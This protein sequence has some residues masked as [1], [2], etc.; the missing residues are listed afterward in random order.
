MHGIDHIRLFDRGSV[1]E[2]L[3][4][5][6]PWVQSAFIS[7]DTNVI[8]KSEDSQSQQDAKRNERMLFEKVT[9]ELMRVCACACACAC[10]LYVYMCMCVCVYVCVCTH[11]INF[12]CISFLSIYLQQCK[13]WA[14]EQGYDYHFSVNIDE[15]LVPLER[16]VS[17]MDAMHS[18]VLSFS[19][20]VV[21]IPRLNFQVSHHYI[22]DYCLCLNNHTH[23][24]YNV[25]THTIILIT[26][27]MCIL[28]EC[29][30]I[31]AAEQS[32]P[33]TLEPVSL[34]TLEAYQLRMARNNELTYF[35]NV[36]SKV[37]LRLNHASYQDLHRDYLIHCCN[38]FGCGLKKKRCRDVS[39]VAPVLHGIQRPDD[40]AIELPPPFVIF[41]YA[42]SLEK[43]ELQYSVNKDSTSD[44]SSAKGQNVGMYMDQ[45]MGESTLLTKHILL[46]IIHR[47]MMYNFTL[48][49]PALPCLPG[50]EHDGRAA[51]RYGCQM[52][53]LLKAATGQEEYIRPGPYWYRNVVHGKGE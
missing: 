7:M 36:T 10:V 46:E 33:H 53:E 5:V 30:F 22:F 3:L 14:Q 9:R 38:S 21:D 4:E 35:K 19:Q 6:E 52:R 41:H 20:S 18:H 29:S 23:Y 11:N 49:C 25:Y 43:F 34:L 28:I 32:S 50:V 44:I 27:T 39:E 45:S 37:A 42:R 16:G 48:S 2:G 24:S 12:A 51:T 8:G 15:Y 31:S 17:V 1:D 40:T 13:R 47:Y 26:H